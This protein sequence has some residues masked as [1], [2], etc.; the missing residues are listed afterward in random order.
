MHAR[1]MSVPIE[2]FKAAYDAH[3]FRPLR[4]TFFP[5]RRVISS[6]TPLIPRRGGS[7]RRKLWQCAVNRLSSGREFINSAL[8]DV[9]RE[10]ADK[11]LSDDER[12]L[13]AKIPHGRC[14]V[15]YM[16]R[17]DGADAESITNT[18]TL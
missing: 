7:L 18:L 16:R 12:L 13:I 2:P 10:R 11:L 5:E 8:A 17:V 4:R 6:V 14:R 15:Y 3:L 9:K 1:E